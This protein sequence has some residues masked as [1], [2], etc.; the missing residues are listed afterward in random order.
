MMRSTILLL[1][2][3]VPFTWADDTELFS[4]KIKPRA[5]L[6]IDYSGSMCWA[7]P[8][9]GYGTGQGTGNFYPCYY[10]YGRKIPREE[11]RYGIMCNA[12]F[13]ILD[14][15]DDNRINSLD[16]FELGIKM[17]FLRYC[18]INGP[19]GDLYPRYYKPIY[20]LVGDVAYSQIWSAI[21]KPEPWGGTPMAEALN[22]ANRPSTKLESA[23]WHLKNKAFPND[24]A[25]ECRPY[26]VLLLTDGE[27]TYDCGGTSGYGSP[28][29]RRASVHAAWRLHQLCPDSLQL[30]SV[31]V[32]VVGFGNLPTGLKRTL[33]W[34]ARWG[35]TD[36]P[37]APNT[38]D[39]NGY[40][41]PQDSCSGFYDPANYPLDG[42]AFICENSQELNRA[43]RMIFEMIKRMNYR[44]SSTGV[45]SVV[46]ER[47]STDTSAFIGS[48]IPQYSPMWEGHLYKVK[49]DSEF[50]PVDTM[51]D[52]GHI[53]SQMDPNL[54]NIYTVKNGTWQSFDTT[55]PNLTPADFGVSTQTEKNA[56]IN[57]VRGNTNPSRWYLGDIFHSSPLVVGAPPPFFYD[58]GYKGFC[59]L[60][61]DRP[62]R[63]YVGANDGMLHIFDAGMTS[64]E[65]GDE[66]WAFIPPDLLPKLKRMALDDTHDYYVDDSPI[67]YGIWDDKNGDGMKDSTEWKTVL[68]GGERQGGNHYY[69]IDI[70]DPTQVPPSQ[71]ADSFSDP[72]LGE[73][74]STPVIHPLRYWS[75][76]KFRERWFACFGGGYDTSATGVGAS[77]YLVDIGGDNQ[78]GSNSFGMVRFDPSNTPGLGSCI[79]SAPAVNDV[80]DTTRPGG[81][82][83]D[84]FADGIYIG[85]HDG[86]MWFID[87]SSAHTSEWR[88]AKVFAQVTA[89]ELRCFFAPSLAIQVIQETVGDTLIILKEVPWL[90][91]G[92]GDRADILEDKTRNRFYAI[93]YPDTANVLTESDLDNITGGSLP[94]T[95]KA[96]WYIVLDQGEKVVSVPIVFDEN[97]YFTTFKPE[98]DQGG[99]Q[100][101]SCNPATGTA[102]LY[103]MNAW[104]GA[105]VFIQGRRIEIPSV[106]VPGQPKVILGDK[107]TLIA[108]EEVVELPGEL[109]RVR[110]KGWESTR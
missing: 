18:G 50:V 24:P 10:Y 109:V 21:W 102:Y 89:N 75:N 12:M 7:P 66:V 47:V 80:I 63:V 85:D 97:V 9:T 15:N 95:S 106:G 88:M 33:N 100:Q 17:G 107:I 19:G 79:P 101:D 11:T 96:G 72:L 14:A 78:G 93:K 86:N 45:P 8:G 2:I 31:M 42:Y 27:D 40:H 64:Q 71:V 36:N 55:N 70:T 91:W 34:M 32:F 87:I 52:A 61:E 54:R 49:L 59:K 57:Y 56:I 73:T 25:R 98:V 110:Y 13:D 90:F 6:V 28:S 84:G 44:F 37:I 92:T 23:R 4:I 3:T 103:A 62:R 77:F 105:P 60:W 99:S 43:L 76:N 41:W 67:A 48:F 35:G 74:W 51:W 30:D 5:L 65:G 83:P 46:S 58:V 22:R 29:R 104:T 20:G 94:D 39:P 1:L 81:L 69:F 82:N 26:A 68:M 16:E 53:L 108:G 38:G